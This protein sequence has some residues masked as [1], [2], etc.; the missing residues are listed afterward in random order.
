MDGGTDDSRAPDAA[1]SEG[2]DATV[3]MLVLSLQ[4]AHLVEDPGDT[5][6]VTVN[7]MRVGFTGEVTF[8]VSPPLEV[9]ASQPAPALDSTSTFE[10]STPAAT[11]NGDYDVV[12]TGSSGSIVAQVHLPVHV[13]SFYEL[14]G[15]SWTVPN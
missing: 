15:G 11:A 5:V 12:L 9:E 4:P 1:T 3:P 13:G 8:L 14:D 7:V 10:V 2:G 6:T